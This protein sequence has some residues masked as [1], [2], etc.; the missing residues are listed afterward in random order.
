[1]LSKEEVKKISDMA[2]DV[3]SKTQD[4]EYRINTVN[5]TVKSAKSTV[6]HAQQNS[7][8]ILGIF[9]AIVLAFTGGLAFSTSVLQNMANVSI[10][11]LLATVLIISFT[12]LNTIYLL[13]K[14]L[15]EVTTAKSPSFH[16]GILNALICIACVSV[17]LAWCFR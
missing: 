12:L 8:A 16:I 13:L 3:D 11:R 7:I 17:F 6:E 2:S 1:M 4:L 15:A 5:E 14:F 9:A 10:Y